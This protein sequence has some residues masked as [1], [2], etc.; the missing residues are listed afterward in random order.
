MKDEKRR[1]KQPL[2]HS[3]RG[4]CCHLGWVGSTGMI[5]CWIVLQISNKESSEN[6]KLGSP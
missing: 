4:L 2:V 3:Q 5:K 1:S 6:V